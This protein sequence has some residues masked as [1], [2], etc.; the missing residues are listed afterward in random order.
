MLL[1]VCMVMGELS[2]LCWMLV[3]IVVYVLV[4][5]VSVLFVLCLYMCS[6]ILWCDMICMKLVFMCC[7]KCV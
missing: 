2:R 4:L 1:C 6:F 3:V 7:G 5:Y